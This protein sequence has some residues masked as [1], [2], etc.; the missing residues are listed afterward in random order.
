[1]ATKLLWEENSGCVA[2]LLRITILDIFAADNFFRCL[3]LSQSKK[4]ILSIIQKN[5]EIKIQKMVA[6]DFYR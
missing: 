3:K 4:T 2:I 1:M 6:I 5:E